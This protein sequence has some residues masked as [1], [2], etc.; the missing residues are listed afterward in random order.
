MGWPG[1]RG[2][3][4]RENLVQ[5]AGIAAGGHDLWL[6]VVVI[7]ELSPIES[8]EVQQRRLIVIGSDHVLDRPMAELVGGA[9]HHTRLEATSGEPDAE[10][11]AV[12]VATMLLR[13][14]LVLRDRQSTDLTAPVD[15]GRIQH[16]A[17]L[18]IVHQ[19]GRGL[20]GS[21]ADRGKRLPDAA[22]IVPRLPL[23][24]HLHEPDAAFDKTSC[25]Q[26]PRAV[27][28]GV[29]VIESVQF[30]S[31]FRLAETSSASRAAVCMRAASS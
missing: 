22:V 6:T 1:I 31:R 18:Q 5:Y 27:L 21:S 25:D 17:L 24:K 13:S 9:V 11:L 26:T 20:V 3:N 30:L 16:S 23:V 12:V 4:L 28:P 8:E 14:A 2:V 10:S 19:G 7:D 15:N 29:V